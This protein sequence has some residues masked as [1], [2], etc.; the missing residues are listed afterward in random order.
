VT[1]TDR[2]DARLGSDYIGAVSTWFYQVLL[3]L[4]RPLVRLRLILRARREPEYG[5]RIEERFGEVPDHVPSGPIWFH[6]VSAGETI[7]AAGL[8]RE[9]VAEFGERVP[10]LVTTMT[11]TGSGEVHARLGDA[12]AHCYAPYDFRDAVR[13]FYDRVAP[14][15]VVLMETELWPNMIA[16]AHARGVPVLLINGRLSAGSAR[17]YGRVGGL[18]RRMLASLGVIA[19]QYPDHARRFVGLGAEPARMRVLGSVKFDIALPFDH[20]ER[21]AELARTFALG[22]RP[23]WIAASTHPGEDEIVLDAHRA[24]TARTPCSLLLVPRHPVRAVAVAAAARLRGF[25]ARLQSTF[26]GGAATTPDVVVCD[27]MGQLQVL[28]G[29]SGVAF[30]GGSL[31]AVGGH[32]PIEAAICAQPVVTGPHTFNF[33]DVMIAFE[34]AGALVRV[35]DAPTLARAISGFLEDDAARLAAGERAAAVVSANRG[36]TSRLLELLRLEIGAAIAQ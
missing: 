23:V 6:T 33:D 21:A 25:D 18:T 29:L 19:C 28:Y 16:E 26:G 20:G 8:V 13:R 10:F 15:L 12:V 17:G 2:F 3:V 27:T 5:R 36:A 22:E 30:V 32:N 14:R 34:A 11:P 4:A 24:I 9:L 35:T 1:S 7:A 31:V